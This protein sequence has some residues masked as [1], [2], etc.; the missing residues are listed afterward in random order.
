MA[1]RSWITNV[2]VLQSVRRDF[3][4]R[5]RA[6]SRRGNPEARF[7]MQKLMEDQELKEMMVRKVTEM[8]LRF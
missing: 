4:Y 6:D 1:S 3:G 7:V 8:G 2:E 5:D